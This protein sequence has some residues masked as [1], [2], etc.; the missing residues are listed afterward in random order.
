[1]SN[2]KRAYLPN[3]SYFFTVVTANR[4]PVFAED[5][6]IQLLRTAFRDVRLRKPFTIEAI[7]VLPDHMHCIWTMQ[8]DCNY[9]IRWQMIKTYFS[10]RY[11]HQHPELKQTKIWQPRYWEHVIRDQDDFN[12]HVDYIHYNPVKHGLIKSV[13]DW[14][15]S[16][17]RK[18]Y[19]Q[20][21]YDAGWGDGEPISIFGMQCE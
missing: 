19:A 5:K 9:S 2:Y 6:N 16:S 12:K 7:C 21:Y 18:F 1:M 3:H 8:N 10:R 17:F 11:R 15:Y 4:S 14:R 13:K 20:G